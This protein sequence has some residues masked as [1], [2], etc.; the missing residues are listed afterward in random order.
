MKVVINS[1]HG[2]F[3]LSPAAVKRLAELNGKPCY[4]FRDDCGGGK[5][6]PVSEKDASK[7]SLFFAFDVPN[8]EDFFDKVLFNEHFL[9]DRPDDRTDPKLIQVVEELGGEH[10]RGASGCCA[11]LSV[12]EIPDGINWNIDEYDGYETIEEAHRSWR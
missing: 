6:T 12:V 4:F 11:K 3:S 2:G 7:D 10:R 9:T 8:P 1:C 5:Y